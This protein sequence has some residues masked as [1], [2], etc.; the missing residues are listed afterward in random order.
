MLKIFFT[1]GDINFEIVKQ[2]PLPD[3]NEPVYHATV[4]VEGVAYEAIGNSKSLAKL[5]ATKK[6]LGVI[7]PKKGDS[8][9][10]I[11]T[12]RHPNTVGLLF[13]LVVCFFCS[14]FVI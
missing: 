8:F 11:D 3:S 13:F 14:I 2:E 7:N 5:R 1:G 10:Q 4:V 6:V 9:G 12:S